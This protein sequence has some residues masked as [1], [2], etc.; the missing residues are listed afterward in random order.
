MYNTILEELIVYSNSIVSGETLSCKKHI[1]ACKR[2]LNDLQKMEHEESFSY[3]GD[4]IEAKKIVSWFSYMKHSKGVLAG[5]PIF[6]TTF[7]KF[8]VCNIYAWKHNE[9]SYRRFKYS[10]IQ[11][12]HK[13]RSLN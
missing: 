3:F 7:Q 10:Y 8:I 12:A 4:E 6:L 1:K 13:N 5:I 11:L 9:T 2:F